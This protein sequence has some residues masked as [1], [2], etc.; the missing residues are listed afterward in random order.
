M[1]DT[2]D[3]AT[4]INDLE[5]EIHLRERKQIERQTQLKKSVFL[6]RTHY[7]HN[8]DESMSHKTGV[9]LFKYYLTPLSFKT[10]T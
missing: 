7:N 5:R 9:I 10:K 1:A 8:N 4:T 6:S 2:I 3:T